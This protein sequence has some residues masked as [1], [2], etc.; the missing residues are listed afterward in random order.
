M[1]N[2]I[3]GNNMHSMFKACAHDVFLLTGLLG[4]T[5]ASDLRAVIDAAHKGDSRAQLGLDMFVYR[6]RKY[7]GAYTAALDGK[8]RL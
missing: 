3:N 2:M 7:I 6:V 4:V 1:M 8:V 5:G